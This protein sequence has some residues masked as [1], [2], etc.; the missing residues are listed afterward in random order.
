MSLPYYTHP[1]IASVP[2]RTIELL[3]TSYRLTT[4]YW[5]LADEATLASTTDT[6]QS[7]H[8]GHTPLPTGLDNGGARYKPALKQGKPPSMMHAMLWH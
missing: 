3:A 2:L 7:P 5:L 4:D 1:F 6:P 8:C